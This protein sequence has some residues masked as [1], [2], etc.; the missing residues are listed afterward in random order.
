[1]VYFVSPTAAGS[2]L[3]SGPQGSTVRSISGVLT[4]TPCVILEELAAAARDGFEEVVAQVLDDLLPSIAVGAVPAL[5]S[6]LPA[7]AAVDV[8][9]T[10]AA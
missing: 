9:A 1:M 5:F 3:T 7:S 6:L 8:P 2:V 10:P 4:R